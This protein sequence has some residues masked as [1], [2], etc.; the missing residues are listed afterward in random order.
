[1]T[2]MTFGFITAIAFACAMALAVTIDKMVE[3]K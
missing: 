3:G 2:T 1:M